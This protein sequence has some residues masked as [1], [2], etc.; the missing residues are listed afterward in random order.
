MFFRSC[1]TAAGRQRT[2]L[3]RYEK[4]DRL[5]HIQPIRFQI[6]VVRPPELPE[7]QHVSDL[8]GSL[9]LCDR[10][11]VLRHL[12]KLEVE[13]ESAVRI[14]STCSTLAVSEV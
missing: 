1:G 2:N 10:L 4:T 14:D 13:Y 6:F 5:N 3:Q 11:H 12:H 9:F 8:L 7:K